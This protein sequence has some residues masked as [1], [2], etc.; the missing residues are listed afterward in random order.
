MSR[1]IAMIGREQGADVYPSRVYAEARI[2]ERKDPVVYSQWTAE[3][4]LSKAQSEFY[5]R[6]GYLFLDNFFDFD[7]LSRYQT[8]A[9][10]LQREAASS[11]GD[12]I[13]REP[14]GNEVRSVFAVHRSHPEFQEL[15]RHPRLLAIVEYLLGSETYIHQSRINYKPGFSGKEFYW[16]SDFE[17]W[18]VED[19]MPRMR[20]LSCSIALEDNYA[21]NGPLML[22]P[23]SHKE[24]VSCIGQTPENHFKDSLRKQEY[25]V[26]DPDS[27]TRLVEKGGI[28]TPVGK[29]GSV[30][31]FDCN[32][33][34]GSNSNITPMPR[35]NIFMVYNSIENRVGSP[36]SGQEPRPEYIATRKQLP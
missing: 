32:I 9:R 10:K 23:G 2:L 29:A 35:S 8:E 17:T 36:Y 19:G 21:F 30:V 1:N 6:N 33:M 4:P 3:S 34:H 28:D 26:P 25:G 13:I 15:S 16:H 12:E 5:D 18:H 22:V 7:E 14:G 27:L 11:E 31:L 20:A 24:F